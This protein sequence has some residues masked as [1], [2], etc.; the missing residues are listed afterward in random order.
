M[1]LHA[2]RDS[3]QLESYFCLLLQVKEPNLEKLARGKIVYEP[4][5]YMSINTV[6]VL[7]SPKSY[8]F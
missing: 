5:R 4:P 2:A 1:F 3:T 6:S 8:V 7:S